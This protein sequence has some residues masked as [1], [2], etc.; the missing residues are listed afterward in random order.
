MEEF[1]SR[2]FDVF[3]AS[4][5][6]SIDPSLQMSMQFS[7]RFWL[8]FWLR[9]LLRFS[10]RLSFRLSVED[11]VWGCVGGDVCLGTLLLLWDFWPEIKNKIFF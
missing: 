3:D 2:D 1:L 4:F 5:E 10:R 8:R 9:D 7:L 6:V 11:V